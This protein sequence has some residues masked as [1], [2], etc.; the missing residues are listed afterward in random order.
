M[1]GA[2]RTRYDVRVIGM[3]PRGANHIS[4]PPHLTLRY[5]LHACK[6]PT[7][8]KIALVTGGPHLERVHHVHPT[9]RRIGPSATVHTCMSSTRSS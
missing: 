4:S 5:R 8:S 7:S 1:L 6:V 9:A 2:A 3:K